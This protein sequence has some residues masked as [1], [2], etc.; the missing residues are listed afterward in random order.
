[1]VVSTYRRNGTRVLVKWLAVITS[2]RTNDT[3]FIEANVAK[4]TI[5]TTEGAVVAM[6]VAMANKMVFSPRSNSLMGAL[7]LSEP[8]KRVSLR[9]NLK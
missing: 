1:M 4:G 5:F 9:R 3:K 2:K 8:L 6:S 7:V